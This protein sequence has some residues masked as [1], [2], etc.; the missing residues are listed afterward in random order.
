[1]ASSN[2]IGIDLGTSHVYI[3]VKNRG[4]ELSEPAIVAV[5]ADTKR[6]VAYGA[7]AY[8]MLGRTPDMIT[9]ISPLPNGTVKDFQVLSDMLRQFVFHTVGHHRLFSR[10]KAVLSVPAGVNDVEKQQLI[11]VMHDAGMSKAQIIDRCIAA[12]LGADLDFSQPTACMVI[13]MGAGMTDIGVLALGEVVVS[14]SIQVGGDYFN[15]YIIR[16]LR[17]KHNLL[18]GLRTAEDVKISLG[19]A[20]KSAG[21]SRT[22]DVTGR[23]LIAGLPKTLTIT[24][25]EIYE[26]LQTPVAD[27]IECIQSVIEHTPPQLAADVFEKGIVLTGGACRLNGLPEAVYQVLGIPC[28]LA[29]DPQNCVVLGCGVALSDTRQ[30]RSYLDTRR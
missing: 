15:D 27:F 28:G 17:K 12:A 11:N 6:V 1:M 10:P 7:D 22:M 25:D 20:Y 8:Q 29:N 21:S 4:I 24:A 16:Y 14:S 2:D 23:D 26:A 9:V 13:D 19:S 3:Y 18:I 30:M 5:N